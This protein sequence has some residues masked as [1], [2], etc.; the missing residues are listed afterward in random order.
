MFSL[1]D[2]DGRRLSAA[3]TLTRL[4]VG[5][6]AVSSR[7]ETPVAPWCVHTLMLTGIPY[8]TLIDVCWCHTHGHRM[9][10]R[11]SEHNSVLRKCNKQQTS[12]LSLVST[13]P[14]LHSYLSRSL[15]WT[16][17]LVDK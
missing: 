9:I 3:L 11:K 8:L 16:Q 14:I 17:T 10:R 15:P 2:V 1:S 7:A 12:C 5:H 6:E 13:L 4:A